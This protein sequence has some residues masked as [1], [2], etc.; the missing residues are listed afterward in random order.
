MAFW[1][2]FIVLI[3]IRISQNH[4]FEGS[5]R[6]SKSSAFASRLKNFSRTQIE[7]LIRKATIEFKVKAKIIISTYFVFSRTSQLPGT[8]VSSGDHFQSLHPCLCTTPSVSAGKA[9]MYR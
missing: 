8:G 4:Y 6:V 1:S 9:G 7:F 2:L 5:G 3:R